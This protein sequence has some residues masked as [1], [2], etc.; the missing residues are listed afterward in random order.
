MVGVAFVDA[1]KVAASGLTTS[2]LVIS[3]AHQLVLLSQPVR[4][5]LLV[6]TA[7]HPLLL[8]AP[9]AASRSRND[10]ILAQARV[11]RQE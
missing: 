3:L 11:L 2:A 4:V 7:Q 10:A 1:G 8:S 9:Q 6:A 5:A